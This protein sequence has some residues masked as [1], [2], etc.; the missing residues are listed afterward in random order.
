MDASSGGSGTGRRCAAGFSASAAIH[1][2]SHWGLWISMDAEPNSRPQMWQT[3][4][5]GLGK[6]FGA[7]GGSRDDNGSDGAV[8]LMEKPSFGWQLRACTSN[9]SGRNVLPQFGQGSKTSS[10]QWRPNFSLASSLLRPGSNSGCLGTG[11]R[12]AAGFCAS[13]NFHFLSHWG[14]CMSMEAEPNSR[15]HIWHTT[16]LG[17]GNVFGAAFFGRAFGNVGGAVGEGAPPKPLAFG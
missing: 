17:R 14:V 5:L 3:T 16:H 4:V 7:A 10:F 15:P 13:A 8:L 9:R 12:W 1:F 11:R 2:F 6:V